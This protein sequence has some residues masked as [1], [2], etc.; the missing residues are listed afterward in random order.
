M[1]KKWMEMVVVL[2]ATPHMKG[3]GTL[4]LITHLLS[5]VCR[6]KQSS[7]GMIDPILHNWGSIKLRQNFLFRKGTLW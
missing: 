6:R 2:G 1:R 3:S 5:F 7:K 4:G